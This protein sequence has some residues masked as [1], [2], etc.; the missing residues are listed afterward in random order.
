MLLMNVC[1]LDFNILPNNNLPNMHPFQSQR[2][3]LTTYLLFDPFCT[4]GS[5]FGNGAFSMAFEKLK[6]L[7][8]PE[9]VVPESG[10]VMAEISLG[11]EVKD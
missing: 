7:A 10:T 11:S 5:I 9:R 4:L 8:L 3:Y 6:N 1:L 2:Y